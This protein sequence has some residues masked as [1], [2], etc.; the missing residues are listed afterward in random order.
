MEFY[1]LATIAAT[2]PSTPEHITIIGMF[3]CSSYWFP[4]DKIIPLNAKY[5]TTPAG[6]SL[7]PETCMMQYKLTRQHSTAPVGEGWCSTKLENN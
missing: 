3:Q 7:P 5:N 1:V 4:R 6:W 2:I